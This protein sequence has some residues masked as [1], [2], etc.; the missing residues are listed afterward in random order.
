MRPRLLGER[1][2][3]PLAVEKRVPEATTTAH[4][5][6]VI[7]LLAPPDVAFP[8][9]DPVNE[10]KWDPDW[11]PRLLADT[12]REGLVFLVG[13]GDERTTW[14]LDLYDP[15]SY[16][17]G[18]V[19]VGRATAT[20]IRI[21]LQPEGTAETKATVAYEKTALDESAAGAVEHFLA[22]F[23]SQ[24]PHWELAINAALEAMR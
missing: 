18:Y 7:T 10:T 19:N 13:E 12:V 23:A 14:M 3:I 22:H 11:R 15:P 8:L 6:F 2:Q 16:R 9:F 1:G 4:V 17:I 21:S 20:R 5:S 24:G